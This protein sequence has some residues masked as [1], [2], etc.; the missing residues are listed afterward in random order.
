MDTLTNHKQ[1]RLF[2]SS[3]FIDMNG[4][5]DALTRVFPQIKE[6]CEKR[7]VEFLPLDLRWGITEE[8]AKE[9]RVIETCLREIDDARPFFIGIIGHRYGWAPQESDLGEF[10]HDLMFKYPWLKSA[11]NEQM[12]I[13]EMEMQHAALMNMNDEKMNAAFYIR[14]DKMVVDKSFKETVGSKEESKLNALKRKVRNQQRYVARDYDSIDQLAEMVLKDVTQFVDRAFPRIEVSSFDQDAELQERILKSRSKSLIP[15]QRYQLQVDKWLSKNMKRDILITGKVGVGKSYVLAHIVQQLRNKGEKVVYADFSELEL[16]RCLEYVTG[17]ML[18]QLGVKNRKQVEN[19]SMMG[20]LFL[21]I[22]RL[23]VFMLKSMIITPFC[24]AFGSREN[25]MKSIRGE[26]SQM[27]S[28]V[29]TYTLA[30]QV[31]QLGK[32]LAKKPNA[33][34]YVA[35]DNMDE[36]TGEDMYLFNV[37]NGTN[38]VRLLTSASV[39]SNTYAHVQS[40]SD[41]ELLEVQ[42]LGIFQ[43]ASYVNNYLAQYGKMLDARGDQCGKLMRSGVAGNVMMLSHILQLMVRFGSYEKLESYIYELSNIKNESELYG[44]MVRHILSQFDKA[45]QLKMAQEIMAIVA[46]TKEGLTESEIQDILH[47]QPMEWALLRPYLFSICRCKDKRWKPATEVCR[48]A[49]QSELQDY[50]KWAVGK[51][52][53]YYEA[54]LK[55]SILH[56]DKLGVVDNIKVMN[57]WQLLKR[58]VEVLPELYYE[59]EQ[60]EDLFYWATYVRGESF[61]KD[62]QRVRYWK[63]LYKAGYNMRTCGDVD[64]PPYMMR[65]IMFQAKRYV[66]NVKKHHCDLY[67]RLCRNDN[68]W[69]LSEKSDRNEMFTRWLGVASFYNVSEDIAWVS[70]QALATSNQDSN[71]DV[72]VLLNEYEVMAGKK[73]WDKIIERAAKEPINEVVRLYVD[74]FATIAYKEKGDEQSAFRLAKRN[75]KNVIGQGVETEAEVLP[76][77]AFYADLSCKYGVSDDWN[78]ALGLLEGHIGQAHTVNLESQ[79]A[80]LLH[81]N[82]AQIHLKLGHKEQAIAQAKTLSRI[83]INMNMPT[84]QADI[85]IQEANKL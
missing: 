45:E 25:T 8:A 7:G 66:P 31:K 61:I 35:L 40:L 73:E 39:N 37:F 36:L 50:R 43:A 82:L 57:D 16:L 18:C 17:E 70:A 33:V 80:L 12:S 24:M 32:A 52:S 13:T 76:I 9:G 85:I 81:N 30:E 19:S 6:L 58:Q 10:A 11:I 1:L 4:E 14:S 15:L 21:F 22:W 38:Q 27:V 74:M 63:A 84:Q 59:N 60:W 68:D 20:C 28:S 78:L 3:T 67:I 2:I 29:Q 77:I 79:N 34:L 71:Q 47:P 5:R 56:R 41:V 23:I 65:Q 64:V 26:M 62:D 83:L 46:A 44:L 54:S 51:L 49:L 48:K 53:N 69:I 42:N 72:K 55:L 75:V